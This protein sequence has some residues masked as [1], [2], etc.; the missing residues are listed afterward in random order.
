MRDETV[1]AVKVNCDTHYLKWMEDPLIKER[2]PLCGG[3]R[4]SNHLAHRGP[5]RPK[6]FPP[7]GMRQ[8]SIYKTIQTNWMIMLMNPPFLSPDSFR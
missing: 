3:R 2:S 8:V 4:K 1:G 5:S 7:G 6:L